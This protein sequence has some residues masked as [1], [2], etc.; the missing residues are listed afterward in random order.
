[1]DYLRSKVLFNNLYNLHALLISKDYYLVTLTLKSGPDLK[2][3]IV[4]SITVS[5][6][7]IGLF[8][9]MDI[10]ENVLLILCLWAGFSDFL[11][12]FLARRLSQSSKIGAQLDQFADKFFHIMVFLLLYHRG[13]IHL[14]FLI[15]FLTREIAIIILRFTSLSSKNSNSL[16]KIKT[17]FS[18]S[19]ILLVL[20]KDYIIQ[21]LPY[22]ITL[23]SFEI[24]IVI[25]GFLSLAL[26]LRPSL[27][28][29][30]N[31]R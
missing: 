4:N 28:T 6:T 1:M 5:R 26:S 13:D 10:P 15:L 29:T 22:D 31:S 27:F 3:I 8:I 23:T 21:F 25:I 2:F 11:D 14:S 7:L 24:L 9:F 12:G 19:L 16:G 30:N 20:L 18:Y 17:A